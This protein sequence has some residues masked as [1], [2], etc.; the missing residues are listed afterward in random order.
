MN[1]PTEVDVVLLG[2]GT[3]GEDLALRLLDAGLTVVGIEASLLGGE[4]PYWACLPSKM[5]IRAANLLTEARRAD[6][7]A[8]EVSVVPDWAPV[9]AR[10]RA[11]ATGGWDDAVAVGR[12]GEHGG[13]FVRGRGRLTGPRTVTV[14]G[15]DFTARKGIVIATGSKPMIPPISGLA[16][17]D[18]WTTHE[19][20]STEH[21]PD[22]LTVLGGGAV[23]CELGQA[24]A[25]FGVDVTIVE[26]MDRLLGGEEPEAGNLLAEVFEREGITVRTGV[27]AKSVSARDGSLVVMLAD[28]TE[29]ASEK[30]L[31]STGRVVDTESLGL[32]AAGIGLEGRFIAVDDR[33]RA[34]DGV[35]A[36]GDVT[37]KGLFTHVAL[38]QG[39]IIAEDL[40]DLDPVPAN[41]S[42]LPRVTFTDPEVGAVGMSEE[43]A[44]AAGLDVTVTTKRLPYTFRGW[45]HGP[46]NDGVI[47]L[48]VDRESG[49]LI[50]ALSAGPHGGEV[51]SMLAT[52]IAGQVP[53]EQL[54]QM[55]YA[56]PTFH[57]AVG[58]ALGAYGLGLRAVLDPETEPLLKP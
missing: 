4:C 37:G 20:I 11:E 47:K 32:D 40:L 8:G 5:I 7:V 13:T 27:L 52:A 56:F 50:G 26:G 54:R 41:H 39:R 53:L 16:D 19:A 49:V 3:S 45:L 51:L 48:V 23:G 9:A 57:G 29:V 1:D 38:Y 10:I 17:V 22:S 15:H 21:L 44:R 55:I 36:M 6:G 2:V 25:R 18:Y 24:F 34:A 30:L 46:G 43:A 35:W 33:L 42:G 14:D 28:G 12:F 31:V 58:E